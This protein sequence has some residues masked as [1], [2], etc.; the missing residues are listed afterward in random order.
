MI[1][2]APSILAADPL[3]LEKA[4]RK[5]EKAGCDWIHVDVMDAH[6][7][8]NLAYSADTVRRLNQVTDL[9]L[10]VH[11]MMDHPETMVDAFLDAGA[12][13]LTIHAETES[14]TGSLLTA[15][16]SRGRMAGLALKPATPLETVLPYLEM[17]DLV[18]M[19]TVEP[20]FG[21][22]KLDARVISKIRGL[23]DM[24]Y[25]GEIE[26]DG[27][28]REDNLEMLVMNGLSVAVMGTALFGQKNMEKCVR[29]LH[30]IQ[31][32]QQAL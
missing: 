20:G 32:G 1:K 16:R 25:K 29:R 28:I 22:Q 7:V 6:F 19:M 18:L 8:P 4:V 11:L 5:A 15:I 12:S 27:G 10:D 13:C 21:G 17:T 9:P 14:D 3:N 26:A 23:K 24:G 30:E 2:I 31:D